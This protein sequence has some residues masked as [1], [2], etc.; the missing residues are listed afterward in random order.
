M[1]TIQGVRLKAAGT[2][3]AR[4]TVSQRQSI[5]CGENA[6]M[7][8]TFCSS[9]LD[10]SVIDLS[11]QHHR[12]FEVK[13]RV[14]MLLHSGQF[15]TGNPG[16][17]DGYSCLPDSRVFSKGSDARRAMHL[18]TYSLRAASPSESVPI[19]ALTKIGLIFGS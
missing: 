9:Y 6:F 18:F 12:Y 1:H 5:T 15:G 10:Y 17:R 3:S 8:L 16:H 11:D 7:V 13:G 2:W 19:T 14:I 4:K